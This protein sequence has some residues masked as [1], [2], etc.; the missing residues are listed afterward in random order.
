MK[1]S[2]KDLVEILEGVPNIADQD[3]LEKDNQARL[4]Q[5]RVQVVKDL[6]EYWMRL[7]IIE[8]IH[9]SEDVPI[10]VQKYK[11]IVE[12]LIFSTIK[13]IKPEQSFQ[14]D[15][16][17]GELLSS[18]I[19]LLKL[20]VTRDLINPKIAEKIIDL[21]AFKTMTNLANFLEKSQED[22]IKLAGLSVEQF[23]LLY[24]QETADHRGVSWC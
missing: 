3:K 13:L 8:D 19:D 2:P 4:D 12:N 20:Y 6:G 7:D 22:L 17:R 10:K 24:D 16:P 21:Q 5:F 1:I 9:F 18:A 23:A 14:N 11:G 15:A